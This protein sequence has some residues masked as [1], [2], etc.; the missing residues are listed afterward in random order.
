ML[1]AEAPGAD[2]EPL[3]FSVYD[4]RGGADVGLPLPVG[5][6]LRVTY[7]VTELWALATKVAFQCLCLL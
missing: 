5:A 3:R 4:K 2:V 1:G 7:I 6:P